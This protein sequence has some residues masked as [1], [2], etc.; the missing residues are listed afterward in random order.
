MTDIW[1]ANAS[2]IIVLAKIGRLDILLGGDRT[3][4]VPEAVATEVVQGLLQDA[5]RQAIESGWGSKPVPVMPDPAVIEWGLGPGETAVLSLAKNKDAVALVD[6]RAARMAAKALGIRVL[7]TLGVVLRA[8][9]EGRI[10][11]SVEIL[12][13]LRQAGLRLNDTVIREALP[14]TTGETWP[15]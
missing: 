3:L 8:R 12:Q 15:G 11:S 7:G 1:I 14:K 2:P 4:I 13:A 10:S 6:D 9:R 5:A